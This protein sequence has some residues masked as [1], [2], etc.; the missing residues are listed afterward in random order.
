M[1]RKVFAVI[2]AVLS[3]IV[4][5]SS[6]LAFF[7]A[8]ETANNIITTGGI[9]IEV[10]EKMKGE[11]GALVEFP[12]EGIRDV[13]PGASVSK[14]VQVKNSGSS[15]AW[16]RIFVESSIIDAKGN[17]LPLL[18]VENEPIMS[19]SVLNGW[20][21]GD[22]GYYYYSVPVLKNELTGMLFEEVKFS[23]S[24][25]NSYQN[26]TAHIIITAQAVQ[27]A[28]NGSSVLDATGWP[29]K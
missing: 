26:C 4:A 12:V 27:S 28:N 1:K 13:M 8:E 10:I 20:I 24:M 23:S 6:T 19:F 29:V 5:A 3:I 14:I 18:S 17:V 25:D 9:G 16:I 15:E 21:K 11:N 2:V 22:D 7:T